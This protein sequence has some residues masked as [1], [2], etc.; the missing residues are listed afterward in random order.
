MDVFAEYRRRELSWRCAGAESMLGAEGIG[1][2]AASGTRRQ[3][4][5][6]PLISHSG[7]GRLGVA[8]IRSRQFLIRLRLLYSC[9]SPK[10]TYGRSSILRTERPFF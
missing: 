7:S 9:K 6:V 2:T 1:S 3:R 10:R 4:A 8:S 5:E